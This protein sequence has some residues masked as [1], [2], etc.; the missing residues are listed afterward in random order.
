MGHLIST[1]EVWSFLFLGHDGTF[2]FLGFSNFTNE[3]SELGAFD[4]SSWTFS[5]DVV[6]PFF[7]WTFFF[8]GLFNDMNESSDPEWFLATVDNS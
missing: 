6:V 3:L 1:C 2:F 4:D 7:F 8:L 5:A